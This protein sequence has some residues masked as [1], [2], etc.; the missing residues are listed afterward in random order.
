MKTVQVRFVVKGDIVKY[1]CLYIRD[2]LRNHSIYDS[3]KVLIQSCNCPEIV[4]NRGRGICT[5]LFLRGYA[6]ED[7]EI[8]SCVDKKVFFERLPDILEALL[9]FDE[10]YSRESYK[11]RESEL[12][13]DGETYSFNTKEQE[14]IIKLLRIKI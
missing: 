6:E 14:Q 3:G 12:I 1:S 4:I 10:K 13:M 9:K 5:R 7:D 8:E 2:I 11:E